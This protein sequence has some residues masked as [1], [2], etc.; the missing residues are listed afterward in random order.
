[1]KKFLLTLLLLSIIL[2]ISSRTKKEWKSFINSN[3]EDEQDSRDFFGILFSIFQGLERKCFPEIKKI[4]DEFKDNVP[5]L[6][7]S[8]PWLFDTVGKSLNDIGDEA[9]C[10]NTL[11]NTSFIMINL[12]N[13][14]FFEF[15]QNVSK[16]LYNFLE[17]L[18]HLLLALLLYFLLL[19]LVNHIILLKSSKLGN[20]PQF[21]LYE[22]IYFLCG[23]V[24]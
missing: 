14:T 17:E 3:N 12:Y 8:Y 18:F 10:V 15:V 7:K 21:L 16:H 6:D 11:K 4:Y 9:E 23:V 20:H 22:E 13:I 1:M 2:K 5:E 24:F 19:F